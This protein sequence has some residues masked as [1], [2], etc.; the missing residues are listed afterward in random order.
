MHCSL[1]NVSALLSELTE[2][3]MLSDLKFELS[4]SPLIFERPS[5]EDW[6]I[7]WIYVYLSG[8]Q[9]QECRGWYTIPAKV[10]QL[11]LFLHHF[12]HIP[13]NSQA[14][15]RPLY[16]ICSSLVWDVPRN[17]I[18]KNNKKRHDKQLHLLI[19]AVNIMAAVICKFKFILV[20]DKRTTDYF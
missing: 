11:L 5:E 16:F 15:I 20:A 19:Y 9:S 1:C 2:P 10:G 7:C 18:S 4:A 17:H 12:N 3:R 8:R 6:G 13:I 14:Y